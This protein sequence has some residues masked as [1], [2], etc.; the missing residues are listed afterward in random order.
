[1]GNDGSSIARVKTLLTATKPRGDNRRHSQ[2]GDFDSVSK[3][4]VCRL[5]SSRLQLPVVSDYRGNLLNK[6][7]VL[8]WL[9]TPHKEDYT[10]DQ[11]RL[12]GH[13]K[14]LKDVV[15]LSNIVEVDSSDSGVLLRCDLG[16]EIWG[17]SSGK[18]A[19]LAEC[20]HVLPRRMLQQGDCPVCSAKYTRPDIITL[21]PSTTELVEL[22]D[23]M[24][25]LERSG[26]THSGMPVK[27]KKRKSKVQGDPDK[28]S[29]RQER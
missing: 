5:S 11:V 6:E 24:N 15:E 3:W 26:L 18:L 22:E 1:M 20:G 7:S 9:L 25:K 2:S 16:D 4:S 17:R 21:N 29:K 8:E 23:R 27:I 13:I 19:Y 14:S 10:E 28:A 12:F